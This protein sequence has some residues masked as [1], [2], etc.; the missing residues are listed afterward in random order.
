MNTIRT[1]TVVQHSELNISFTSNLSRTTGDDAFRMV[2]IPVGMSDMLVDTGPVYAPS[3]VAIRLFE[4]D[5]VL[6]GFASSGHPMRLTG[7]DDSIL[8]RLDV[9]G[10]REVTKFV[11]GQDFA[12]S[13][14]GA[15]FFI[16][17]R[18]P[19]K[20]AAWFR[21]ADVAASGFF[22]ME[23]PADGDVF[24]VGLSQ[25]NYVADPGMI[26]DPTSEFSSP[27]EM[28]ALIDSLP[29]VNASVDPDSDPL[30]V[31]I[32]AAVAGPAGD[33]ITI[34]V[35]A[36][37]GGGAYASDVSLLGGYST[38]AP[39]V[40][41]ARLVPVTIASYD[42]AEAVA[43]AIATAFAADPSFTAVATL[44]EV[45]FTDKATGAR[46]PAGAGTTTWAAPVQ[47]QPGIASP[48]I[49]L[50]SVGSSQVSVVVTPF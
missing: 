35:G 8:L 37:N 12:D 24:N 22:Y 5:D 1:Q 7:K 3:H 6:V 31:S 44:N 30:L 29:N 11:T 33:L 27:S 41:G 13:L 17:D 50:K 48:E 14:I 47:L 38:P 9:P 16:Y 45:V 43:T 20:V 46:T 4:G 23:A 18:T 2:N 28:A 49:H 42:S 15:H 10:R 40:S 34:S 36:G 32:T 19:Q 25:F 39:T 26:A 21:K